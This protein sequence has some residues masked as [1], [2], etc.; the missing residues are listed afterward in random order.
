[1]EDVAARVGV[2]QALVSLVFRNAPGASAETRERVFRAA[3][4]L[5][6]RPNTAAQVLRR[7][8]S[9]HVGA[10]FTM[11]HPHD[12]ALVEGIYPA[13]ER[14]GYDVALGAVGPSR[15]EEKAVEDL[16]GYSIEG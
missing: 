15:D 4:E 2:S 9:R 13:A 5:G 14:L 3:A 8:R 7:T 6:Y 12:V 11:R 16:L 10:L 1:M